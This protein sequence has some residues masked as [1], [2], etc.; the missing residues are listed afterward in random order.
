MSIET[1][2]FLA[3][4]QQ[5][6]LKTEDLTEDGLQEAI[7]KLTQEY[8]A[9]LRSGNEELTVY[10][11][12]EMASKAR[13]KKEKQ[14]Y[15]E[16]AQELDPKNI[17][18]R[19]ELLFNKKLT[20]GEELKEL[21]KLVDQTT[22]ELEQDGYFTKEYI[23]EF[24]GVFETRPYIR[25]RKTYFDTLYYAGM[26]R[27]AIREGKEILRL[28]ESDNTGVR[29]QLILIYAFLGEEAALKKLLSKYK[30]D[31]IYEQLS[32]AVL[33]Y[34]KGELDGAAEHIREIYKT[35]PDAKAFFKDMLYYITSEDQ[36]E[37]YQKD[38]ISELIMAGQENVRVFLA[39]PDFSSWAAGEC[40]R[41]K[42]EKK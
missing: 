28:N 18:V 14:Q 40:R 16:K 1:E 3:M 5:L 10:D 35:V 4:L 42:A 36:I 6:D 7:D 39:L 32:N 23:G 20:P 41:K 8:N 34:A 30:I 19:R 29:F 11:Y 38:D 13:S 24:Y 21:A 15:L 26:L 33:Y 12:L 37:Y 2:K 25:L 22:Q 27:P 9:K 31:G 17:D